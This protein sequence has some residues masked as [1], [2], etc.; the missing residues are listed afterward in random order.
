PPP[1]CALTQPDKLPIDSSWDR[2]AKCW[3]K[4]KSCIT[5]G[6]RWAGSTARWLGDAASWNPNWEEALKKFNQLHV[7]RIA[8][9]CAL[10]V[11][12]GPT[13]LLDLEHLLAWPDKTGFER[14]GRKIY[15]LK[16]EAVTDSDLTTRLWVRSVRTHW[17][18]PISDGSIKSTITGPRSPSCQYHSEDEYTATTTVLPSFQGFMQFSC[19]WQAP[20]VATLLWCFPI[21]SLVLMV[22]LRV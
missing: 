12:V 3:E 20:Q 8:E 16:C 9:G 5:S 4:I 7:L 11:S 18:C 19:S 14:R 10:G 6:L 1:Q 22:Y 15:T 13:Y 2:Q 17:G 21:G